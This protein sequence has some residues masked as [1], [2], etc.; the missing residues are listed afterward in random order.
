MEEHLSFS[1]VA[2]SVLLWCV[3]VEGVAVCAFLVEGACVGAA[4][5]VLR[6]NLLASGTWSGERVC[7]WLVGEEAASTWFV[8]FSLFRDA[9]D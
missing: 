6:R 9:V 5:N 4:S 3:C 8:P 2:E 1:C 7:V